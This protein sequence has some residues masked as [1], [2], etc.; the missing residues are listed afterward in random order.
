MILRHPLRKSFIL[1]DA[2]S[3]NKTAL[4]GFLTMHEENLVVYP[5]LG[6]FIC[7]QPLDDQGDACFAAGDDG[8]EMAVE[9]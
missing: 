2:E 8:Q 3:M 7:D 1:S 5:R 4:L 6:L 9:S